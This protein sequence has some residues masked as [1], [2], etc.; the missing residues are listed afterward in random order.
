M[1]PVICTAPLR[2][3][4]ASGLKMTGT[5]QTVLATLLLELVRPFNVVDELQVSPVPVLVN[6]EPVVVPCVDTIT[7]ETLLT[8]SP[9]EPIWSRKAIFCVAAGLPTVVAGKLLL[10]VNLRTRLSPLSA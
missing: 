3:P 4:A 1:V 7:G 10:K 5:M 8:V 6:S 9:V 2:A